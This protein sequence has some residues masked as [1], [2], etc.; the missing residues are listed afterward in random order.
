MPGIITHRSLLNKDMEPLENGVIPLLA[1]VMH[2]VMKP[3]YA[4]IGVIMSGL[5]FI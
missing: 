4:L 5:K 1:C 3:G 2:L